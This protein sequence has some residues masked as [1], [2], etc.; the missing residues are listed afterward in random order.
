[1]ARLHSKRTMASMSALRMVAEEN[2]SPIEIALE[3][4][5]HLKFQKLQIGVIG[6]C[7]PW[8]I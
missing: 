3:S 6:G 2:L 4:G 5:R 7:N 8:G 1:M